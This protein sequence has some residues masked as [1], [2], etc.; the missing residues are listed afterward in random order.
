MAFFSGVTNYLSNI[1]GGGTDTVRASDPYKTNY[2][3]PPAVQA[4]NYLPD[5]LRSQNVPSYNPQEVAAGQG[6][7]NPGVSQPGPAP[8]PS[9]PTS[10]GGGG[11]G[12]STDYLSALQRAN[13]EGRFTGSDEERA[14][15]QI[16]YEKEQAGKEQDAINAAFA[17]AEQLLGQSQSILGNEQDLMSAAARP[18]EA[19]MPLVN[20][21]RDES[22]GRIGQQTEQEQ[23]GRLNALTQARSLY[24]EMGQG[25]QNR[26]GASSAGDFA[27]GLQGR[28][29]QRQTGTIN[30]TSSQNI[31]KLQQQAS[32]VRDRATAQIQSLTM[33]AEAAKGQAQDVFRQ[34]LLEINNSKTAL[35]SQKAEARLNAAMELRDRVR[36]IQDRTE[37]F[38]QNIAAQI[39]Q[40]NLQLRNSLTAFQAE[41]GQGAPQLGQLPQ[42]S[43]SAPGAISQSSVGANLPLGQTNRRVEEEPS[44][45]A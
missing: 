1:F 39:Q 30:T 15:M 25:V 35:A 31:Q 22:L 21:A 12:L 3:P 4:N 2:T 42:T 11:G 45:F 20:Q 8:A 41:L 38:R 16:A 6:A 9:A 13:D 7:F 5:K 28:E 18:Y 29:L 23:Y 27:R 36:S 24:N 44:L 43:F 40:A 34:R 33:Q 32:D 14:R 37:Q 10:S 17:E 26:F 19:Q